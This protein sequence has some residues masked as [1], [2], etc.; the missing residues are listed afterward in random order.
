MTRPEPRYRVNLPVYLM[1]Q[2][3]DGTVRRSAGKCLNLSA[4]GALVETDYPLEPQTGLIVHSESFGRI[5]HAAVRYCRR[6]TMKYQVGLLFT[7]SL[8]LADSV[9]RRIFDQAIQE[10]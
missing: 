8:G 6:Q 5:G 2:Q 1:W 7:A 3:K 4:S 10:P 9:R